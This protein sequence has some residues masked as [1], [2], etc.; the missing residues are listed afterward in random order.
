[1]PD[2]YETA[3]FRS[4]KIACGSNRPSKVMRTWMSF[5]WLNGRAAMHPLLTFYRN[6]GPWL[7]PYVSI[8]MLYDSCASYHNWYGNTAGAICVLENRLALFTITKTVNS[9]NRNSYFSFFWGEKFFVFNI[10][11]FKHCYVNYWNTSLDWPKANKSSV[12]WD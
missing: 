1:M 6:C 12:T 3:S 9:E 2:Q 4:E 8:F 10:C 5:E 7:L 11:L